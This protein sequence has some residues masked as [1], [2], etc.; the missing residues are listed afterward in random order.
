MRR[1]LIVANQTL[2][3]PGLKAAIDRSLA[4][5]PCA[6]HVVVPATRPHDHLVWTEGEAHEIARARL[7]EALDWFASAGAN[8]T[9]EIGDARPMLA[10]E[11]VL[12]AQPF[13]EIILSTLPAGMSRWLRQDLPARVRHKTGLQ[14]RHVIVEPSRARVSA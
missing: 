9:G 2:A 5:G 8:A 7:R 3:S 13:D 4:E 11:D 6:F 14:V 1:Y 10:I 12:I